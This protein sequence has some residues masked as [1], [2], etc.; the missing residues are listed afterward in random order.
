MIDCLAKLSGR[1]NNQNSEREE[2]NDLR[3]KVEKFKKMVNQSIIMNKF[4]KISMINTKSK[5]TAHLI[6]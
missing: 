4:I 2:L 5:F 1:N 3:K 6:V